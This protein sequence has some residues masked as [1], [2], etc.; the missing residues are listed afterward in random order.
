MIMGMVQRLLKS[1]LLVENSC[2]S[3]LDTELSPLTKLR[4]L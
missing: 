4:T 1:S 2:A 3:S